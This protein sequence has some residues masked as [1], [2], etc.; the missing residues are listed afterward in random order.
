ML[1]HGGSVEASSDGPGLGSV[2]T[3]TLP[4]L[5]GGV[6]QV[7]PVAVETKAATGAGLQVVI[8]DD[9]NDAAESLAALLTA[10]GHAMSVYGEPFAALKHRLEHW[11][12]VFILDIGLPGIDG[13]EL[14]RRLRAREGE[15]AHGATYIALTGYGQSH[16]KVLAKAAGFDHYL[17]KPVTMLQLA[18]I[19]VKAKR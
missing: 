19:L 5:A 12:D 14:V 7:T 1:L 17:V 11:P 8:V 13:Y 4:V 3:V 9:N 18:A 16:D 2:F 10:M 15:V 6:E